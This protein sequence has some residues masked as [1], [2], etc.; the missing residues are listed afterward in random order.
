MGRCSVVLDDWNKS[1]AHT[2]ANGPE[3]QNIP[4]TEQVVQ[5]TTVEIMFSRRG[6]SH[7]CPPQTPPRARGPWL[8]PS[9][10][11]QLSCQ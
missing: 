6:R 4:K 1:E 11:H 3:A 10:P 2:E 9:S 7:P 5:Q 8:P